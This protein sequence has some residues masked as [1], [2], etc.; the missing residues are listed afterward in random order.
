MEEI[1]FQSQE[2][3]IRNYE[4]GHRAIH[5]I[6]TGLR[7]G[8]LRMLQEF[9][10]GRSKSYFCIAATVFE[11]DELNKLVNEALEL[12]KGLELKEKSKLLH[13]LLDSVAQEKGYLLKLRK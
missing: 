12:S 5:V 4:R 2:E 11:V 3:K 10:E 1:T 9:N 7:F 6:N 13:A 8:I